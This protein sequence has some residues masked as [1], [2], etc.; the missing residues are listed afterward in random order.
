MHLHFAA[1]KRREPYPSANLWLRLLDG[2]VLLGGIIAPIFTIPQIVLIYYT[3]SA[4]GVSVVTW[5]V[6]ALL[7]VPWILYGFAH[8]ERAIVYSYLLWFVANATVA[9][10]AIIYGA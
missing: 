9:V 8:K 5:S 4:T 2:I 7:D 1:R 3:H 6:Y 10:G